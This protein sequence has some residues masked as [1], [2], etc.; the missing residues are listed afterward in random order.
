M[1]IPQR[2]DYVDID[3]QKSGGAVFRSFAH[4]TLGEGDI[5]GDCFGVRVFSNGAAVDMTGGSCVGYFIRPDGNTTVINGTISGNRAYVIVPRACYSY[6]GSFTL[7]IKVT[8]SGFSGTLRIVDGT[9]V[10]TS[11]GDFVDPGSVISS[12]NQTLVERAE[13]AAGVIDNLSTSETLIAG[14]RY[15][16]SVTLES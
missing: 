3:L 10:D 2:T 15:K 12:L 14:D 1:A 13:A 11:T 6:I 16:C 5:K 7:S 8:A 4:H 9:V